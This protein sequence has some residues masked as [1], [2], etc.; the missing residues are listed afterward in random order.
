MGI[1]VGFKSRDPSLKPLI[2]KDDELVLQMMKPG[3]RHIQCQ[4]ETPLKTYFYQRGVSTISVLNKN[5][6]PLVKPDDQT[7]F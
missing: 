6:R 7:K 5:L 2:E 1:V 3:N 4:I